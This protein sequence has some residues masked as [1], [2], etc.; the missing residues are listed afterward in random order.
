MKKLPA[1]SQVAEA[2]TWD[3]SSLFASDQDWEK[4]LRRLERQVAQFAQHQGKLA[5]SA[6]ALAA[7][8]DLDVETDRLAERLGA[9]AYLKTTQDQ[10]NSEYQ[11]MLG[12][13]QNIATRAGEASSFIRPEIMAIPPA[14]MKV[15][16]Q[17]K[18]LSEY[19]LAL[20][21][22]RRYRKY[23]LAAREEQLLAMQGE[24][25][26]AAGNI[27]RKLIDADLK[28]GTVE[29]ETGKPVELTNSSFS[30]LLQSPQ[31]S[32][33]K[34]AFH[35]FYAEHVDHQN[36]LAA[37]LAGSIQ[38]DVYYARARGYESSLQRALFPD[39]VPQSVYDN[40][41]AAVRAHLPAVHQYLELRRRKM[42]LRQIHMYDTYVPLLPGLRRHTR[43]DQAVGMIV[44]A[45]EPLGSEYVETLQTGLR[46]RWCD[47]YPNRHKQ[48]GAFSY[49]TYAA[50]PFIMMNYKPE[51][52]EDVFTLA[53]EAGHSMHT[54][55][56]A[57]N[58]PFLY[59]NYT[60]FVAEVASTFN[61]E[62]L[63]HYLLERAADDQDRA[64][65]LN[66]N[67]DAIR[68]TIV[69]QT[70]FAEFEK[71]VHGMVEQGEPLTVGALRDVYGRLLRDYFGPAFVIDDELTLEC[72]RIPHFYR[73]FYVYKYA[74]GLSAA[75][76]LSRRVLGG[77]DK[78]RAE[79]LS[80][81]SGGC[82]KY[83]LELLKRAG[84]DMS[85]RAP[86]D[87]SL[88]HF[89]DMVKELDALL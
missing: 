21:R 7:C 14:R 25:A 49:G 66:R 44:A 82:A 54:Y 83:P 63:S 77:G 52:F 46:G 27:F 40:L 86:I 23:T 11:R 70:M 26:G 19:A 39:N 30:Q 50:D 81:L 73:S 58:Q 79:Y 85:E 12:R 76:A 55:F 88:A 80:F 31:R 37:A 1:R 84:V 36:S 18:P 67:V 68:G 62:L 72:L 59:Y 51:V 71:T 42:K 33:R 15:F 48:S 17:A 53:H 78:E 34:Q 2:D 16:L 28:F 87:T 65:L 64:F 57:R 4:S 74:T 61:E 35:Q 43:W 9:Y 75:I 8:L 10:T 13:Y 38:K 5:R 89:S 29:D 24:M 6:K 47:R 45:L 32:V 41:I 22:I 20:K 3:L 69:R 56:S 60:I